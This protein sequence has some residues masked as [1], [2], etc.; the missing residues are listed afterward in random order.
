MKICKVK[1]SK[2]ECWKDTNLDE[3]R[4]MQL[5][6]LWL[7]LNQRRTSGSLVSENEIIKNVTL[8]VISSLFCAWPA[9]FVC[10]V[11]CKQFQ[12]WARWRKTSECLNQRDIS[13]TL[14]FLWKSF[15]SSTCDEKEANKANNPEIGITILVWKYRM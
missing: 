11:Q 5:Q 14:Y 9:I 12:L 2:L 13:W 10:A 6:D 3:L 7:E 8:K 15:V 4:K 1:C